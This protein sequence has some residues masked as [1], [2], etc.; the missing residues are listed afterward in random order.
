M[1][2]VD[3]P[4]FCSTGST[5]SVSGV[6]CSIA[7]RKRFSNACRSR[8][9]IALDGRQGLVDGEDDAFGGADRPPGLIHDTPE[10]GGCSLLDRSALAGEREDIRDEVV[11][12][13]ERVV[14]AVQP[15]VDLLAVELPGQFDVSDG[16]GERIPQVVRPR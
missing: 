14:R 4:A 9:P 13:V 8:L 11:H 7:F 12:P 16:D 15:L 6:P 1:L 3:L 2:S 10:I 5:E